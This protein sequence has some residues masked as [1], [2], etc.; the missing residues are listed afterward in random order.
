MLN[1]ILSGIYNPD[2]FIIIATKYNKRYN[3]LMYEEFV[4][5]IKTSLVDS[6][7]SDYLIQSAAVNMIDTSHF[8]GFGFKNTISEFICF[9]FDKDGKPDMFSFPKVYFGPSLGLAFYGRV[10]GKFQYLFD[11]SGW[12]AEIKDNKDRILMRYVM[13]IIDVSETYILH[14]IVYDKKTHTLSIDSKVF[15][16]QQTKIPKIQDV[17][18]AFKTNDSVYLRYSP[19][20][21]DSVNKDEQSYWLTGTRMLFGNV[22]AVYPKESSGYIFY[23]DKDWAF[24]AFNPESEFI[25]SSLKHGMD[26]FVPNYF[27]K[28]YVKPYLCGWIPVNKIRKAD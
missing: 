15:Y 9:D 26:E 4:R 21:N 22:D 24:V 25:R 11:N 1:E 27:S 18:V 5:N 12:I 8:E 13:P 7:Y 23:K 10:N 20:I 16:A 19:V 6:S 3:K 28:K 2:D 14:N 17:P